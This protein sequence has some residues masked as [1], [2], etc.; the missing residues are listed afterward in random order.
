MLK[1]LLDGLQLTT[2]PDMPVSR[3]RH[4]RRACDNCVVII[5]GTTYPVENWSRGGLL[6]GGDH[7]KFMVGEDIDF[8]IKFKVANGIIEASH[9]GHVVRKGNLKFA[10]EFE[11]LTQTIANKFQQVIDDY[12]TAEFANSQAF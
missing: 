6:V 1:Q 10:I 5:N 11:P 8:T 2:N 9:K 4:T 3:R 7:R 12:I